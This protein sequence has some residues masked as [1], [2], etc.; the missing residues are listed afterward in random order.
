VP[1][2]SNQAASSEASPSIAKP[3]E[4][5]LNDLRAFDSQMEKDGYWVAGAGAGLGY[6][7]GASPAG[8]TIQ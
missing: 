4:T 1:D 8:T 2:A 6:P 3:A 5:C 7:A